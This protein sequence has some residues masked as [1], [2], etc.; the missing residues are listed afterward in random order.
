[1]KVSS[2]GAYKLI[3]VDMVKA[4]ELTEHIVRR[5]DNPVWQARR[6][7]ILFVCFKKI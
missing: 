2:P 3:G 5:I 7:Q 4:D 6:S 1:V